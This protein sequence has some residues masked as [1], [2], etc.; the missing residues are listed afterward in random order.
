MYR[1]LRTQQPN[2]QELLP[3]IL[4][5]RVAQLPRSREAFYS[6]KLNKRILLNKNSEG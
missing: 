5:W 4:D 2:N 3:A 6:A 1:L